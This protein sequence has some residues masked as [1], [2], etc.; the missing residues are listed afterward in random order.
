[1]EWPDFMA[2]RQQLAEEWLGAPIRRH[3]RQELAELEQTRETLRRQ[4]IALGGLND[5][6][7]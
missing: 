1:M 7:D 6:A 2:A 4:Q 5:G 3:Q